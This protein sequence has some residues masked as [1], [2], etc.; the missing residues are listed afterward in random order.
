M[1]APFRGIRAVSL[2]RPLGHYAPV[3]SPDPWASPAA[4]P[5]APASSPVDPFASADAG[6]APR[7]ASPARLDGLVGASIRLA[8]TDFGRLV[9]IAALCAVGPALLELVGSELAV[10]ERRHPLEALASFMRLG[11]VAMAQGSI[12]HQLGERRAGRA[13]PR[14]GATRSVGLQYMTSLIGVAILTGFAGLMVAL[15]GI[16]LAVTSGEAILGVVLG[17][18]GAAI[19]VVY[20]YARFLLAVPIVV[21][22]G[23]S[24]SPAVKRSMELTRGN[25]RRITGAVLVLGLLLLVFGIVV[26][27]IP[28]AMGDIA[29]ETA[30]GETP[31]FWTLVEHGFGLGFE[32]MWTVS[33]TALA[34]EVFF[35]FAGYDRGASDAEE[36][37]EIF[38]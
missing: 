6:A 5:S 26:L 23:R 31:F 2:L 37:A 7:R 20:I 16:I 15:P 14:R 28:T 19:P 4:E 21:C 33:M 34:A 25:A 22:E 32:V 17:V 27:G 8:S 36:L 35:R 3:T 24:S 10:S 29:A 9:A 18:L 30:G 13:L 11:T 38:A 12:V 1:R